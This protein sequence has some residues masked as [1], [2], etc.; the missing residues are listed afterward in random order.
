MKSWQHGISISRLKNYEHLYDAYNRSMISPFLCVNKNNIADFINKDSFYKQEL[1]SRKGWI[2]TG[3]CFCTNI[4]KSSGTIYMAN[5]GRVP[6]AYRK[7]GDRVVTKMGYREPD[8]HLDIEV[9]PSH[10]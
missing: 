3:S 7:M 4:S 10:I 9:D 1:G 6:I 2:G 8:D 5:N